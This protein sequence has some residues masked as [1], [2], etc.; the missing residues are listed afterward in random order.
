MP[1]YR[2]SPCNRGSILVEFSVVALLLLTLILGVI[3]VIRLISE[4][5]SLGYAANEAVSAASVVS[6]FENPDAG[7]SANSDMVSHVKEMA[8]KGLAT[9]TFK[10][11]ETK[12]LEVT[13]NFP[14][15]ASGQT[16]NQALNSLP[17]SVTLKAKF[18]PILPIFPSVTLTR[19]AAGYV[20]PRFVSTFPT[21][22]SCLSN[23]LDPKNVPSSDVCCTN[24]LILKNGK[25]D[26]AGSRQLQPDNTCSSCIY[27]GNECG[28]HDYWDKNACIC[29]PCSGNKVQKPGTPTTCECENGASIKESCNSQG[30]VYDGYWCNCRSCTDRGQYVRPNVAANTCECTPDA[31]T[32]EICNSQGKLYD[33]Y[34]CNCGATCPSGTV[35]SNASCV[36]CTLQ[37]PGST[38]AD[39]SCSQCICPYPKTRYG[40]ECIYTMSE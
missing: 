12:N 13:V 35:A 30:Q 38:V 9:T 1:M 15:L 25:C 26:C 14:T 11:S 40:D 4:H 33:S 24:G 28:S 31:P 22:S 32:K 29:K 20:E 19:T 5:S 8:K 27:A 16:L 7:T 23:V 18:E 21:A 36:G 2:V 10:D 3:D 34:R 17:L 39:S 37:C 6:D